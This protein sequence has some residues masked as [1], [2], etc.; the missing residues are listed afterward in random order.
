MQFSFLKLARPPL[1]FKETDPQP[2]KHTLWQAA[3]DFTDGQASLNRLRA[4][5][6][7]ILFMLEGIHYTRKEMS[8]SGE[9]MSYVPAAA[10]LEYYVFFICIYLLITPFIFFLPSYL[11]FFISMNAFGNMS[12]ATPV[13]SLLFL[14]PT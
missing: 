7:C 10:F 14:L 13:S 9:S 4:G 5:S 8:F 3:S 1:F 2:R 6:E 12:L 11:P